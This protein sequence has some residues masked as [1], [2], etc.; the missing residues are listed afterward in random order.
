M[1]QSHPLYEIIAAPSDKQDTHLGKRGGANPP[2][3]WFV[4]KYPPERWAT[5]LRELTAVAEAT[6]AEE[7][8]FMSELA[9]EAKDYFGQVARGRR[10]A[11]EWQ[12]QQKNAAMLT[13]ELTS[14]ENYEQ[15]S[16]ALVEGIS[17]PWWRLES[18]CFWIIEPVREQVGAL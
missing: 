6:V 4:E 17:R 14:S 1:P 10:A 3:A 8:S 9:V 15:I 16:T 11:M 2:L 13:N 12:H 7:F 5:L 18:V